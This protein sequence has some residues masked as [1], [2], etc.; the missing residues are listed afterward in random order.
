MKRSVCSIVWSLVWI[1]L[2]FGQNTREEIES[3]R[4]KTQQ[5]IDYATAI[6]DET[7]G[8]RE[9][10]LNDLSLITLVLEKREELIAGLEREASELNTRIIENQ[11]QIGEIQERVKGIRSQYE[12]MIVSA[13]KN[14]SK[15]FFL[16]Y[17]LA[18]ENM[19]QAYKRMRYYKLYTEYQKDLSDE[20]HVKS[21]ELIQANEIMDV[22]VSEKN[23]NIDETTRENE[24][25]TLEIREKNKIIA[26]LE[27]RESEL[28]KEIAQKENVERRLEAELTAMIE[29]EKRRASNAVL[30]ETLTPEERIISNEFENNKG[31]LPWPT[32]R[33]IV[34]GKYGEHEYKDYRSLII[35][36][37]G[38][39]ISTIPGE[40]VRAIF[41]GT[42][43]KI[44]A[45]PGE[46]YS[47][48]IKH[49]EYFTVY[50]NLISV[51]VVQGQEVDTGQLLGVVYTDQ[52]THESI[53]YF[54]VWKDTET[55]NPEEWLSQ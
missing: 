54:Q 6:L 28:L 47:V 26:E 23:E 33:G 36:N 7:R 44:F 55:N 52:A 40:E 38:I 10:S 46:N 1:T 14:R 48:M 41:K 29:E 51:R 34:T 8:E 17:L 39:Y 22:L 19:N 11:V 32:A 35:R 31:R 30:L 42:V 2:M 37:D 24:K 43:K 16:M 15:G 3:L 49:G 18:S 12:E 45:I 53:C 9:A 20:L 5:E 13:Y 4:V 27:E 25:I 50:H 21:K